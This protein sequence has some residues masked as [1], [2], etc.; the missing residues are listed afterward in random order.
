M[1]HYE[2]VYNVGLYVMILDYDLAIISNYYASAYRTWERRF[3]ARQ[4]AVILYEASEDLPQLLGRD[5]R[6][7]L[8][9]LPLWDGAAEDLN[10]IG[11]RLNAFK[12]SNQ[13]I[14]KQLRI[15][16]GAHRDRDAGKQLEVI[17]GIEPLAIYKL[18]A[19]FYESIHPLTEFLIKVTTILGKP[20]VI[21]S[22][23]LKTPE[24]TN[25][26]QGL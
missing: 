22:H 7:T 20:D 21:L 12:H 24:F 3:A 9:C 5:F 26:P 4:L 25:P 18:A 14:L 16:V 19:D 17:D 1:Q 8:T 2:K 13:D 23:L 10:V 15:F 11:K 6:N